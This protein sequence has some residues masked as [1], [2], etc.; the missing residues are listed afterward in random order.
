VLLHQVENGGFKLRSRASLIAA[1]VLLQAAVF[2]LGWFAALHVASGRLSARNLDRM[3]EENART[4]EHFNAALSAQVTAPLEYGSTEWEAAQSLVEK[5]RLRAGASL[6]LLD[7]RG[8]VICHP[9]LRRSPNLRQVDYSE[10]LITLSPGGDQVPLANLKPAGTLAGDADLL[11]GPATLALAYNPTARVRVVMQQ[12]ES[13]ARAAEAAFARGLMLWGGVAGVLVLGVTVLGSVL[14]VRRYDTVL[15]RANEE[16]ELEVQRRTRRGLAIRNG[17]I[18]GL[19]KLADYRDTDTGRHLERICRY[20]ELLA[21]ELEPRCPEIDTAW[22]ERLRLASSMHDIG[23]VGVPDAVLLKPGSLTAA[24]RR[25][26]EQH[27]LIGADTL[28]A[29]RTRVGDDDLINM[30]IQVT[31]SHHE[32]FD[33]KGYPYGLCDEQI[34]LAARIVALADV[35]DALTS[36]RVYKGAMDHGEAAAVIRQSR[37]THFDP[38]VVAAFER[39]EAKFDAIRKDAQSLPRDWMAESIAQ[40]RKLAA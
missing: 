10:Q 21:R 6:F 13:S 30:G 17:V 33:G 39:V 15:M 14:L 37:G 28:V 24:E 1:T 22:I 2:G 20:S 9:A 25:V 3:V 8:R 4:V 7:M 23:K 5:H 35:Y 36:S 40:A 18:F 27:P 38:S 26:M 11:S 19:A 16:L 29:I 31:L 34:P 32:R 12:P